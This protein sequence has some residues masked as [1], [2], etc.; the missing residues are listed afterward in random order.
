[1]QVESVHV[2]HLCG[3]MLSVERL[4]VTVTKT[5]PQPGKNAG[6]SRVCHTGYLPRS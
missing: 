4:T 1:M 5:I 2:S 3:R 6:W